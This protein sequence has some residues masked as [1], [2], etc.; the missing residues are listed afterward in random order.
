MKGRVTCDKGVYLN[1]ADASVKLM[2]RA[3]LAL[4]LLQA[5]PELKTAR[6]FGGMGLDGVNPDQDG[7]VDVAYEQGVTM[8]GSK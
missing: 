5:K 7:W 1:G 6:F 3:D 2:D 4:Q 8:G